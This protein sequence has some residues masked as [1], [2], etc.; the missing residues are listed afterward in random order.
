[1]SE[2]TGLTLKA[3]IE[4]LKSRAFSSEELTR[5]HS[6]AVEAARP[7]RVGAGGL[8]LERADHRLAGLLVHVIAAATSPAEQQDGDERSHRGAS[9]FGGFGASD[10]ARS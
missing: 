7:R 1:M 2:F 5:A 10:R 6:E 3:A 9:T 4:G 8:R